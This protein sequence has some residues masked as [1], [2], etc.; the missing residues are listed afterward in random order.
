[1]LVAL[2]HLVLQEKLGIVQAGGLEQAWFHHVTRNGFAGVD[3]FFVI[4]GFIM[5]YVTHE[6]PRNTAGIVDFLLARIG[7]I[8]PLWCFFSIILI[9]CVLTLTGQWVYPEF[10][11][12]QSR[13]I[14]FI[15]KSFLLIPQNEF[16]YLM[17][18]WTL[19]HEMY[20]YIVFAALL[21][22]PKRWMIPLLLI[23]SAL[24]LGGNLAGWADATASSFLALA[25]HPLTLEFIAGALVGLAF[26]SGRRN[27][28]RLALIL[29]ALGF[30]GSYLIINH[31]VE[32][33]MLN[34]ERLLAYG[35]PACLILYGLVSLESTRSV[36][37]PQWA[38]R[39]GDAS[40]ALYLCHI[41]VFLVLRLGFEF[42][43]R[44]L[45]SWGWPD[46]ILAPV[47][48]GAPGPLDNLVFLSVGL[49]AAI[50][51]SWLAHRYVEQ[52]MLNWVSAQRR[53]VRAKFKTSD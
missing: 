2:Y 23:W 37:V 51:T 3:L 31:D 46:W 19:I 17:V 15:L 39:L 34:Y 5:V 38:I 8:Y 18:G 14:E 45:E 42:I 40:Y 52:A 1:M 53:S 30:A 12:P 41:I 16:P 6:R 50:I 20:F 7:R 24:V 9:G 44:T 4:S 28:A 29:G 35:L 22:A 49:A 26:V 13:E 47:R 43:T 27:W 25:V 32:S 33:M 48:L 36:T 10:N 21:L 11:I